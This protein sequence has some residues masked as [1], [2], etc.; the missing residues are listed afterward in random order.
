[1][2]APCKGSWIPD[3]GY[4]CAC[5]IQSPGRLCL[6]N[7]ESW[8]L[9]SEIPI[10]IGIQNRSSTDED[11]NPVPG[12]RNPRCGIQNL[13]LSGLRRDY[14]PRGLYS[15]VLLTGVEKCFKT[16]Y[17]SF[18][19]KTPF[20]HLLVQNVI[21]NQG[22]WGGRGLAIGCSFWHAGRWAYNLGA[23]KRQFTVT[24]LGIFFP[25]QNPQG[26]F[27]QLFAWYG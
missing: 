18:L 23:Y 14:K 27:F 20:S 10:T 11:W 12:I 6:W 17:I 2:F 9:E 22:G 1:M 8:A 4:I 5:G 3:R 21:I 25:Y 26:Q 13:R 19:T 7:P 15:R 24:F 16:S